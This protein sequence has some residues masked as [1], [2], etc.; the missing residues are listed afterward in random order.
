MFHRVQNALGVVQALIRVSRADDDPEQ[1]RQELLAGS[2]LWPM[3]T[4]CLMQDAKT[5]TVRTLA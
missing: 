1:F 3:P 5:V 2:R 4:A